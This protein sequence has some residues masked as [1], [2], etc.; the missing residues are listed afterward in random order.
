MP[1]WCTPWATTEN[2]RTTSTSATAARVAVAYCDG[3]REFALPVGCGAIGLPGDVDEDACIAC[4]ACEERCPV[5]A[6]AVED[7]A[8]VDAGRCIGCGQCT[9]ACPTEAIAL[10]RRSDAEVLEIPRDEHT[11]EEQRQVAR[12]E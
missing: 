12:S 8:M 10:V 7:V 4:G 3:C 11:W 6:I 1:A 2:S 9:L 5:N